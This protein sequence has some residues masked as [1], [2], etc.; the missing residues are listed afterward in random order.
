ML[1]AVPGTIKTVLRRP[2][3]WT[4]GHSNHECE[5]LL[6]LF[7]EHQ[8]EYVVDVRSQRYSRFAPQFHRESLQPAVEKTGIRYSFLAQ[9][10]GG[11]PE[12]HEHYDSDGHALYGEI[13][14]QPS[15]QHALQRVLDG[16]NRYRLAL[17]AL[18]RAQLHDAERQHADAEPGGEGCDDHRPVSR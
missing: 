16:A 17:H 6:E 5:R 10:L 8:I 2:T 15:F 7:R 3:I 4:V 11:R 14:A 12:R 18:A 13:A 1:S 9:A